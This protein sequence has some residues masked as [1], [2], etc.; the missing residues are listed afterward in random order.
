MSDIKRGIV[1]G[2]DPTG[3]G[4]WLGV[5]AKR[6]ALCAVQDCISPGRPQIC[7]YDGRYHHHGCIHYDSA[8]ANH[9]LVFR[10]GWGLL[11]DHHYQTLEEAQARAQA[12]R[13]VARAHEGSR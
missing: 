2:P 8:P 5:P 3:F 10:P 12:A 9:G 13:L 11:C 7:L 4:P 1:G 6:Q